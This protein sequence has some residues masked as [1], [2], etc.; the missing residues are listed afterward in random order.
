MQDVA[1]VP[2]EPPTD[3]WFAVGLLHRRTPPR[4][5]PLIPGIL[6]GASATQLRPYASPQQIRRAQ[7]TFLFLLR[8]LLK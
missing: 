2:V 3:I 8:W 5:H 6:Y 1:E 4:L 7:R